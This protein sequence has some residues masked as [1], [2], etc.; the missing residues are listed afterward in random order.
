MGLT[1]VGLNMSPWRCGTNS[2]GSGYSSAMSIAVAWFEAS[3]RNMREFDH[4]FFADQI[5]ARCNR[6]KKRQITDKIIDWSTNEDI[7]DMDWIRF[8]L[9][10]I[11]TCRSYW[12]VYP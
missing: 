5:W 6:V 12:K 10:S 7:Y 9:C 2:F 11:D 3:G 8:R 1:Q 4:M